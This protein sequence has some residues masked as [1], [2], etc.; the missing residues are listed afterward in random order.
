MLP[1]DR[2]IRISSQRVYL[3]IASYFN[4]IWWIINKDVKT[5]LDVGCGEGKNVLLLKKRMNEIKAVGI[6]IH[7]QSLEIAKNAKCYEKLIKSDVSRR[8]F[9]NKSFDCVLCLQ[10]IEHLN[11]KDVT[12][13]IVDL[14]K[15]ARKQVIISTP[16]GKLFQGKI[17]SNQYQRHQSFYSTEELKKRGFEV[18]CF[19]NRFMSSQDGIQGMKISWVIK[20]GLLLFDVF[21]T[22]LYYLMPFLANHYFIAYKQV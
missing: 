18:R 15:C 10:V 9:K 7:D 13:L 2:R 3:E 17:G 21:L 22:P 11:K 5:V 6:D 16:I 14:E 1:R 20:S 12:K 8:I 4:P 19:G